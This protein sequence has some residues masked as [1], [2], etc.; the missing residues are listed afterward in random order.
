M[1]RVVANFN[2]DWEMRSSDIERAISNIT[3]T[4]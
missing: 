2:N 4:A 1:Q 3:A